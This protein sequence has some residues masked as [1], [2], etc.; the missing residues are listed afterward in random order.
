MSV[1]VQYCSI[2]FLC[3][4]TLS[5]T[6]QL[7]HEHQKDWS[8]HAAHANSSFG[9]SHTAVD[10]LRTPNLK[11]CATQ[12]RWKMSPGDAHPA[13]RLKFSKR[14]SWH[15][16][17]NGLGCSN[18]CCSGSGCCDGCMIIAPMSTGQH[19]TIFTP[20]NIFLQLSDCQQVV[21]PDVP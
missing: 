16:F 13:W 4:S 15:F 11:I 12:R 5:S 3:F 2:I 14:F 10:L 9:P 20:E 1:H 7:K 6:A 21:V 8:V 19:F 18:G 17:P